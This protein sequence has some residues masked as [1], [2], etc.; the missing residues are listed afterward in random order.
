LK[1]HLNACFPAAG[2]CEKSALEIQQ[3]SGGSALRVHACTSG[4]PGSAGYVKNDEKSG[5]GGGGKRIISDDP[6]ISPRI[7]TAWIN[8]EEEGKEKQTKN[9]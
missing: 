9:K 7:D 3:Y 4:A 6:T 1:N 5:P 2:G 8:K